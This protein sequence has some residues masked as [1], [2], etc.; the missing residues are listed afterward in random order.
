MNDSWL[1]VSF[2]CQKSAELRNPSYWQYECWR[3][4]YLLFNFLRNFARRIFHS[5]SFKKRQH[6]V[7]SATRA[8]K[9]IQNILHATILMTARYLINLSAVDNRHSSTCKPDLST[10][11]HVS[12]HHRRQYQTTFSRAWSRFWT[13]MLVINIKQ[14]V[15][16]PLDILFQRWI[17]HIHWDRADF[18]LYLHNN[19]GGDSW[20]N[21]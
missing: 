12:I 20:W 7:S 6:E 11:C 3:L 8:T 5:K 17:R 9:V 1:S 18:S 14:S 2:S 16:C 13:G 21:H 10:L 4:M 15:H 19:C